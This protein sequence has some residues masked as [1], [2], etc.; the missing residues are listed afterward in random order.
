[1]MSQADGALLARNAVDIGK[2]RASLTARLEAASDRAVLGNDNRSVLRL[3][4]VL[5]PLLQK[6]GLFF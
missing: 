2:I 6:S 4:V 3:A 1:M 5:I